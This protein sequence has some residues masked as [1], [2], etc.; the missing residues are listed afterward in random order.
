M[1]AFDAVKSTAGAA[2]RETRLNFGVLLP[3]AA[4]A[5]DVPVPLN[6]ARVQ[7][8]VRFNQTQARSIEAFVRD[9]FRPVARLTVDGTDYLSEEET[10]TR[11]CRFAVNTA[12]GFRDSFPIVIAGGLETDT[13]FD[14]THNVCGRIVR[15]RWPLH[16]NVSVEAKDSDGRVDLHISVANDSDVADGADRA[17]ALRTSFQSVA[18]QVSAQNA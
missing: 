8:V 5:A 1:T 3:H 11:E 12:A 17:T 15:E 6:A 7:L 18:L 9:D 10:L 16:G 4:A 2:S 14:S 13:L